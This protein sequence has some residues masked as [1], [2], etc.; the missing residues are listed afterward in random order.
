M[1]K[2]KIKYEQHLNRVYEGMDLE[3]VTEQLFYLTYQERYRFCSVGEIREAW[4][5]QLVGLLIR[6]FDSKLFD[7]QYEQWLKE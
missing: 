1:K 2:S 3:S 5:K 4:K 7:M 6:R